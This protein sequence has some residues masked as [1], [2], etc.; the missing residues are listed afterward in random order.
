[1]RVCLVLEGSYPY[2]YGGV[3][4]WMHGCI[5]AMPE[6]E[7]ILWVIGAKAADRGKFVYELP[8]NVAEVHEV[9]LDDA[10]R[11]RGGAPPVHFTPEECAALRELVRLGAPDWE[12]LFR[13]FHEKRAHPLAV[14]QSRE[15]MALF[16]K[17][18]EEEYPYTAF[19]DAFHTVRSMLLPVLWLMTGEVP[20]ADCYH[21]ICTGY[22]GLLACLGGSVHHR[23]VLLTEHGIYTREREEEIIRAEWVAPDFKAR[24]TRFFYML[25]EQIYRQADRVTSL[26]PRARSIQIG[27]GCEPGKC[28]VIPNGVDYEKF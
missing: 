27:M 2:V 24:W 6:H 23:P 21:A 12:V 7:F 20:E 10:L 11:L 18:C 17:L 19:A 25:S 26:F 8:A 3:S 4:T 28:I 1:M 15:F 5:R 14:L 9:F 13:L 22:G 16:T